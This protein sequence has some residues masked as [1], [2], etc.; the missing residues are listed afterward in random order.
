MSKTTIPTGGITADA[1]NATL[2]A[3]DAISEEHLDATA[4]TA[5]T[6]LAAIPDNDDELILSDGG[7][8]KRID[9]KH[10]V[11][12]NSLGGCFSKGSQDDITTATYT[13]IALDTAEYNRGLTFGSNK[14]T[15]PSGGDGDY[16]VSVLLQPNTGGLGRL[17]Q[18]GGAIYKNGSSHKLFS[19]DFRRTS[20]TSEYHS[21]NCHV[22]W[23]GV[24]AG[25]NATDYI[26]LY[27]YMIHNESAHTSQIST[28]NMVT[29]MKIN[30]A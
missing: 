2:I 27:A 10:L 26:E 5:G 23:S 1:I 15:I 8:L 18:G 21:G 22:Q 19:I 16:F 17:G 11:P 7:T 29:I 14:I 24:I 3:D 13:K 20:D 6:D 4:I 12:F 9:Y 25:L 28:T 30:N